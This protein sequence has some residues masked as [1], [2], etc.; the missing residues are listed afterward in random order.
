MPQRGIGLQIQMLSGENHTVNISVCVS[1]NQ[2]SLVIETPLSD[3]ATDPKVAFDYVI[4]E[5]KIRQLRMV[6]PCLRMK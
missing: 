2:R 3:F 6:N 4:E 5:R 1:M